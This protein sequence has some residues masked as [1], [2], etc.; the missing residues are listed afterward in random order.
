M[1]AHYSTLI[2][3]R[4]MEEKQKIQVIFEFDRSAYDAYLFLMGQKKNEETENIWNAMA[5]EQV[6][7]DA[8][9]LDDDE[10]TVKLMMI[11]LAILAVEKKVKK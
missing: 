5:E 10:N 9:L 8:S 4:V 11:S 1:I 7:A 6:V 2:N 3:S